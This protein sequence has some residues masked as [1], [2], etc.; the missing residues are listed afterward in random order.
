MTNKKEVMFNTFQDVKSPSLRAWNQLNFV[1]NL[2]EVHGEDCAER[3]FE[4]LTEPEKM[5]LM[6]VASRVVVK[7]E[8]FVR[9]EIVK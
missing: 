5:N 2:E 3:Y 1:R 7:G 4:S 8:D 9:N 6:V